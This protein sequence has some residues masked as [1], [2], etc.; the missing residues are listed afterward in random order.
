MNSIMTM[1]TAFGLAG[2]AGGK[3]FIP[4]LVLGGFHYTPYFELSGSFAWIADPVVMI[5]LGVLVVAEILVDSVPEFGQYADTIAYLPKIVAGFIAFAAATGTMD[6]DVLQLSASGVLGGGTAGAVH[7]VRNQ[8][9]RPFRDVAE[10][11]HES[12]AKVA[13][14]GE[15][16]VSAVISGSAVVAPPVAV[17]GLGGVVV[18]SLLAVR[19]LDRRTKQCSACGAHMHQ[20]ALACPSCGADVITK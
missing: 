18:M 8:V 4:L 15:A 11:A 3:A 17:V 9:R 7:W 20:R 5:V 10:S 14:L 12:A 19:R 2:G 13:S 16:G 6:G 1:M